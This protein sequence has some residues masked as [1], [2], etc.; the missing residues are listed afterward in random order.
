MIKKKRNNGCLGKGQKYTINGETMTIPEFARKYN[1]N[2]SV[3]R[4][5][6]K[7]GVPDNRLLLSVEA[8]KEQVF[9][10]GKQAQQNCSWTQSALECYELGGNCVKCSM[11]NDMKNRCHMREQIKK[12][13]R[14]YGRPYDRENNFLEE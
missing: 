2:E 10:T 14:L 12:I 11:P 1:L 9:N 7:H 3:I 5:R 13:I 8:Y 6:M 4:G